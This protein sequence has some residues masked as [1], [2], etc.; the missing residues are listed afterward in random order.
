MKVLYKTGSR[1]S[2]VIANV[3]CDH[4]DEMFTSLD[5]RVD[6]LFD[7]LDVISLK[8]HKKRLIQKPYF[9]MS[10]LLGLMP[11]ELLKSVPHCVLK[12]S[13]QNA[14]DDLEAALEAD[15]DKEYLVTY[16]TIKRFLRSLSRPLVCKQ[17]LMTIAKNEEHE[18]VSKRILDL[19]PDADG[20]AK[21]VVYSVIGSN[22]GRLTVTEGPNILTTKAVARKAL[23]SR[24]KNGK[25]LQIDLSAA[26][27]NIALN[28][29]GLP[30]VEDVYEHI[31]SDVLG[32]KVSRDD[33]K[34]I[35]L[36]ALYGQSPKNLKKILPE[37]ISPDYV[38]RKTRQFFGASDLERML[39]ESHVNN[40]LRN[41]V[42][43]PI[44]LSLSD[45]RLLV[46]YFLQSSAAELSI[47]LF[48]ELC[49]KLS[50]LI[51]PLYV[52][53]DALIIDCPEDLSAEFLSK[54]IINL[55]MGTWSFRAK[56]T[57]VSETS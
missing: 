46:S 14:S 43:R 18:A 29:L 20:F 6:E 39:F 28:V 53:H 47:I 44:N 25:V 35:T 15:E 50:G 9:R 13:F 38:I 22:T 40:N 30:L 55:D 19:L 45:R 48:S 1:S 32:G 34:I 31:S 2:F 36:C 12:E 56:I 37:D 54:K 27:P 3:E 26:E 51:V 33:A 52:I 57:C 21:S 41:V 49:Q 24:Y 5:H 8:K 42:G 4:V 16:L 7:F 10:N 23:K 11:D 17:K